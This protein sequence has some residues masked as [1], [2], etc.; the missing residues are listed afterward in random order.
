MRR[1]A[2]ALLVFTAASVPLSI[3]GMQ[4]G[5]GALLALAV[6]AWWLGI[7]VVRRTPLDGVLLLFFPVL[8][9]STLAS[10]RPGEADGWSRPWVVVGFYAVFWWLRD[11][12]Q[13]RRFAAVMVAA[14]TVAAIYGILQHFTGVDWWRAA[15]GRP[16]RVRPRIAG[17]EGF[18]VVGFFRNYLT[19]AHVMIFPLAWALAA[20]LRGRVLGVLAAAVMVAAVAF[21]T[22]RGVWIGALAG[23][24]I[25]ALVGRDR[26]GLSFL[27]VLLVV[28]ALVFGLSPGLRQQAAPLFTLGGENAQ[29]VA[30]YEANRDIVAAHPLLGL[31][32]GRYRVAGKPYYEP[33]PQADR[34]SHA[35]NNFLQIAAEAGLLGLAAFCLVFAWILRLGWGAIRGAPDADTWIAA[36]GAWLGIVIF[37][38]AGMTQY[39][40][41]DNEVAIGMWCAAAV[42][43]RCREP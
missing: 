17:A 15:L 33:Y 31:G 32:F 23:V 25:L 18:A 39:N 24:V 4:I 2:D 7:G 36:T 30:I 29:R 42:L 28:A 6:A 16:T 37:L 27:A 34:K 9:L 21:S 38:I 1:A 19:F 10:L 12:P 26:R 5:I 8:A 11:R 20:A 22:A 35:H 14:G 43:L 13:A 40:F 41:G 3:S